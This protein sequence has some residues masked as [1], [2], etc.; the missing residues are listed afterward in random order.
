[1]LLSKKAAA[2]KQFYADYYHQHLLRNIRFLYDKPQS[3]TKDG[4]LITY[5]ATS[6]SAKKYGD[7]DDSQTRAINWML[8]HSRSRYGTLAGE[9]TYFKTLED[10]KVGSIANRYCD[11]LFFDFDIEDNKDVERLKEDV[12][13][14]SPKLKGYALKKAYAEVQEEFRELIFE[15]DLLEDVFIQAKKLTD[16]LRGFG[17]TPYFA[18]SGSKGFH[19]VPLFDE[20][21]LTNLSEVQK[22]LAN[23]Y[24]KELKLKYL[25]FKVFDRT[26]AHKRLQRI[27]YGLHSKTG[28]ITRPLDVN[29][30]YDEML[31]QIKSTDRT[32]V[33]FDFDSMKAPAGFNKMLLKIDKEV[34]FKKAE[35]KKQLEKENKAKHIRLKQQYGENYKSFNDIDLRNIAAA[36]GVH[37]KSEADKIVVNCPFHNDLH[38][39]AVVYPQRFYCSTCSISLN[40]YDFISRLE[41][42]DDKEKILKIARRFL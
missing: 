19:V 41:G 39:S 11:R 27:P 28:L 21:Q 20:M 14:I 6:L 2:L 33:P 16:Y 23:T 30:T 8:K 42:T 40:Y 17:I 24:T 34:S 35:R 7:V 36:Y 5:E 38:P 4:K 10:F 31:E 18:F 26:R 37:G 22:T 13:A 15:D 9:I 32:P 25:D 29:I 3:F 12:K 1:M